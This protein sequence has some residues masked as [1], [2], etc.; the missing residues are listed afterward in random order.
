[1]VL[2]KK[3]ATLFIVLC[4]CLS[5]WLFQ[6]DSV[7]QIG[8]EKISEKDVEYQIAVERCYSSQDI[9]REIALIQLKNKFLEKEVLRMAF[10]VEASRDVLE[11]KAKWVD[12][13][14]KAPDILECVKGVFGNDRKSY[15]RIYIQPTLVNP[16]LH[17][18]FSQSQ[19]IHKD[20]IERIKQIYEEVK[21]GRELN[22][23]SE[24]SAFEIEKQPEAQGVFEEKGIE[25]Q[26]NPLVGKVLK[27][28]EDGEVWGDIV[29]DDYSY[30]IVRLL[31]VDDEKYY[32]DGV[33]VEKRRFDLWFSGFAD[34][35][36]Y[37]LGA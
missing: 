1:M 32:C 26:E 28:L 17:Y 6:D 3:F 5:F 22:N 25:F 34:E 29:E 11:E 9:S 16:K 36:V 20:E 23:F 14:T 35:N 2:T 21:N 24:Y 15:L 27:N 10:G 31:K 4:L 8:N 33:A 12:E 18:L 7:A 19:E 37:L 30:Q 13:N